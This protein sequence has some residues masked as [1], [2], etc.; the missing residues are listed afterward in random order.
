M[1]KGF[2]HTLLRHPDVVAIALITMA[3]AAPETRIC[4][5]ASNLLGEMYV[6]KLERAIGAGIGHWNDPYRFVRISSADGGPAGR[7]QLR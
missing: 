1:N 2:I 7:N 3:A 6:T 4:Q 5:P